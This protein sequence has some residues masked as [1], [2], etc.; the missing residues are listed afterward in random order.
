MY[1]VNLVGPGTFQF[2]NRS[3]RFAQPVDAAYQEILPEILLPEI[4]LEVH[5][6][7]T[8]LLDLEDHGS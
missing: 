3:P 1:I 5:E 6:G 7:R 8:L 2:Q 4:L